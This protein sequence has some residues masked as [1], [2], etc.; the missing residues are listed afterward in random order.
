MQFIDLNKQQKRIKSSIDKRIQKVLY[1]GNY[2]L[3][4]EVKELE[5]KLAEYVNVDYAIG[6]ANGSDALVLALMALNICQGDAVF[7]PSFTFFA[8]ASAISQVGATPI[9]VDIDSKTFNLSISDLEKQI[10]NTVKIVN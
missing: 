8:S 9:F 2:I 3:G 1:H 5:D 10:I 6:V 7:V 4:P